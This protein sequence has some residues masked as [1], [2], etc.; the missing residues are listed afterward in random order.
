[1]TANEFDYLTKI[2]NRYNGL[3]IEINRLEKMRNSLND[4]HSLIGIYST[5]NG[6]IE[7]FDNYETN[8]ISHMIEDWINK[9]VAELREKQSEISIP[10]NIENELEA[11]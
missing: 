7:K 8:Q 11:E 5:R 6:T 4:K 10:D 1:M 3:C 9:R 2:M